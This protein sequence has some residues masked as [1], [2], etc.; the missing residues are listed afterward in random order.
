MKK[1]L[2]ILGG[3][4][5]YIRSIMAAKELGCEVIVTDRNSEAEGFAHADYFDVMDITDIDGSLEVA[6]KFE[7]DGI[8]PVNDFGVRTAAAI[9]EELGLVGISPLV[10]EY[11][12]NKACMRKNWEEA[13]VPSA[14]YEVVK[15]LEE[16]YAAVEKLDRWPLVLKPADSRGGASRGVSRIIN[17]SEIKEA[18]EFAQ[19]FYEDKSVVIEEFLDGIEH[20][21]ETIT[22]NRETYVL[23]VSDK[24][25][26]PPPFRVD[27]SVIYPTIFEDEK[28]ERIH[29]VAKLAVHALGINI[30]PA[31]IELCSTSDGPK[32]FELGARC[33]GGGTPD[34]IVP[35]LTGIEMFK[36]VVR[37]AL[38]EKPQQLIPSYTKGCVYHFI[39]PQPGRV[40]KITGLEGIR[41]WNNILDFEVFI[42]EGDE[43]QQVKTGGDR[44]GFIIA[45][46]E[47][48][49]EAVSLTKQAEEQI[50]F[51]YF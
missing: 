35:F 16:A 26:T 43:V 34:P 9:A 19:S 45:G 33:G 17:G 20:S 23:A 50:R 39:T 28:L 46:G 24:V 44:A 1:R 2:M 48:R 41:K 31:H 8:V 22:Y 25:K 10:A 14:M 5:Y 27:K 15:S 47:T 18:F 12:T 51:E 38:G 7:I 40:R 4:R 13:G 37:I 36:E 6:K 3:S 11:T 30:G 29:E 32:L 21:I 42:G 49:E